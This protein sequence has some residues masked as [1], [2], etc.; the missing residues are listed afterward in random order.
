MSGRGHYVA[1]RFMAEALGMSEAGVKG[2]HIRAV[3]RLRGLLEA[4]A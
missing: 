1:R 4:D 2:R 3:I